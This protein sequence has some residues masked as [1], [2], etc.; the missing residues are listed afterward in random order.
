MR[1]VC[2]EPVLERG[3]VHLRETR[4]VPEPYYEGE[5]VMVKGLLHHSFLSEI[6]EMS[7]SGG[8]CVIRFWGV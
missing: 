3:G 1:R 5:R 2:V 6:F 8:R 7:L 4:D